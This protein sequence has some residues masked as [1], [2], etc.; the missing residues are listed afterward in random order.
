[1]DALNRHGLNAVWIDQHYI[2]RE[3]KILDRALR[4]IIHRLDWGPEFNNIVQECRKRRIPI[5][6]DL[7]DLLFI[8]ELIASGA[9]DAVSR[10]GPHEI[11]RWIKR[12]EDFQRCVREADFFIGATQLLTTAATPINQDCRYIFNGFSPE[13]LSMADLASSNLN[14][15]GEETVTLGYASG[16][17]THRADFDVVA[18]TLWQLMHEDPRLLLTIVGTL[19]WETK[20]PAEV[21]KRISIRPLVPHVYLPFELARF[22]INITPL[23]RNAFCDA[24]SPLKFFEAGLVNVPTIATRNPTYEWIGAISQGC[25]LAD[26]PVSWHEHLCQLSS[27]TDLRKHLGTLARQ[28]AVE[29]FHCDL[30]VDMYAGLPKK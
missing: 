15:N 18:A 27:E 24:K 9:R 16:T 8:P 14:S 10:L 23:E 29:N 3:P 6:Y 30:T 13:N 19:E 28:A 11:Q 17:A 1:M 20:P 21:E 4:V 26:D 25:L 2:L 5:G 22:D 12:S 7:D